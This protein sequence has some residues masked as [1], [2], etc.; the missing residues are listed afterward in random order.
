MTEQEK[1][2]YSLGY[3]DALAGVLSET[4]DKVK[5]K[6]QA[7]FY[8]EKFIEEVKAKMV[9]WYKLDQQR[10]DE[11]QKRIDADALKQAKVENKLEIEVPIVN[12]VQ[13]THHGEN[14]TTTVKKVW[15]FK[16]IDESKVPIGYRT[17][18]EKLIR[19][20]IKEGIREIEG[21]KIYQEDS[22]AIR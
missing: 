10:R 11:E 18:D 19:G 13:K 17:I 20:A 3:R 6:E 8:A 16:I 7:E 14:S 4:K 22:I 1:M 15:T 5:L 2:M 21:V 12:Q 9:D